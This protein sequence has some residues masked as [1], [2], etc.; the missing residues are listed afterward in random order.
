[1]RDKIEAGLVMAFSVALLAIFFSSTLE[2]EWYFR[3]VDGLTDWVLQNDFSSLPSAEAGG[4]ILYLHTILVLAVIVMATCLRTDGIDNWFFRKEMERKEDLTLTWLAF[5]IRKQK[6]S[7]AFGDIE[8][9][10]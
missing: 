6:Q 1:M 7:C 2:S 4:G 5:R 8:H 3:Q 9:D 10:G